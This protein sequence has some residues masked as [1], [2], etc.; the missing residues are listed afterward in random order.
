MDEDA[1]Q[2]P[3]RKA[4]ARMCIATREIRPISDLI[5]FVVG[6]G[7]TLVPDIRNRLPG[8]GVWVT[9]SRVALAQA[10]K[11]KAFQRG[12][13]ENVGV[14]AGLEDQVADLLRKDALQMFSLANK[15]GALTSGFAKI[16]GI[17]GGMLALVQASDG[18][19]AE[20]ARLQRMSRG[21]GRGKRDPV[22][23]RAFTAE[24]LG[25]SIGR[26]HVIHAALT[27]HDAASV[28]L[29][30]ALRFVDFQAGGPAEHPNASAS[31][32]SGIPGIPPQNEASVGAD[33]TASHG[34]ANEPTE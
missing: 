10:V 33:I 31:G 5:R 8:R 6:P 14:P 11:R 23:I 25:L 21:K 28:F 17:R 26:E 16:E 32:P 7:E 15:A 20:V 12:L 29:D 30:R 24:E 4:V 1:D 9:N 22:V 34:T 19:A 27:V 13:K 18:S 3:D 2:G